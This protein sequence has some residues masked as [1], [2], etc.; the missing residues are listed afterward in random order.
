M[1]CTLCHHEIPDPCQAHPVSDG[2]VCFR[3]ALDNVIVGTIQTKAT[4]EIVS[5]RASCEGRETSISPEAI[6]WSERGCW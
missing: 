6:D 1:I 5:P 3:C 2:W 4:R